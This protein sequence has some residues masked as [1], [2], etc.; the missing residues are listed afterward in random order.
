MKVIEFD[1]VFLSYDEPNA[2]LHY[3]DLCNKVPWAKRVHGVVGFDA[4]HRVCAMASETKRFVTI[5]GDNWV[6]DGAFEYALDDTGI[7]DVCF[8]F[9]SRN[10]ING[11]EYG[12]GGIKVWDK[13]TFLSSKTH[14]KADNTDFHWSIRYWQVDHYVSTSVNNCTSYQAWRAGYREGIKMSYIGDTPPVDFVRQWKHIFGYNLSRL[15]I[16]CTVGRDVENGIWAMLGA[17]QALIDLID[18]NVKHTCINDYAWFRER[19]QLVQTVNPDSAAR[20]LGKRLTEHGF[21]IPEIESDQSV[22]FKTVYINPKREG[23]MR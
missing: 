7:E 14:E 17:R 9:K 3:A 1:V 13:E 10:I 15:N 8:S 20:I 21:Y 6:N 5:D 23:L 19:W 12:N 16:W 18:G 4:A 2:D 22:W 11:L